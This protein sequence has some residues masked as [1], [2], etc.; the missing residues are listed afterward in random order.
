MLW[1]CQIGLLA[2]KIFIRDVRL[3][4]Q[5]HVSLNVVSSHEKDDQGL[6]TPFKQNILIELHI[7]SSICQDWIYILSF[8]VESPYLAYYSCFTNIVPDSYITT[9]I[10]KCTIRFKNHPDVPSWCAW[11]IS[12]S[13]FALNRRNGPGKVLSGPL[14]GIWSVS[15]LV[16]EEATNSMGPWRRS[17]VNVVRHSQAI[18][19]RVLWNPLI[20]LNFFQTNKK[21]CSSNESFKIE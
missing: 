4:N 13:I 10:F 3:T 2:F 21:H 5:E 6:E 9:N 8:Q 1:S 11:H 19:L 18:F 17:L 20:H 7:C 15:A 14:S 16:R 12:P